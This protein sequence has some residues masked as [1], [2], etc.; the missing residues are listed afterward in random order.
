[1]R[2]LT[3]TVIVP[4]LRVVTAVRALCV[5]GLSDAEPQSMHSHAERGNDQQLGD[6]CSMRAL[7]VIVPHAP[8][9]NGS[10]GALRLGLRD[11]ERQSVHSHAER[12]ND[13]RRA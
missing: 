1:M 12:G 10:P 8:R 9:G 4:T 3:V 2:A 6:N 5:R 11:A 13:R 7:T